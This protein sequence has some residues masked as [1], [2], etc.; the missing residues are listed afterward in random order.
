[1]KRWRDGVRA[2]SSRGGEGGEKRCH[3]SIFVSDRRGGEEE[4]GPTDKSI[5]QG[6]L[7]KRRQGFNNS[8]IYRIFPQ[9]YGKAKQFCKMYVCFFWRQSF[10]VF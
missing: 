6:A 5:F 10:M 2:S 4:E 1:M 9:Y 7:K 8:E 3:I